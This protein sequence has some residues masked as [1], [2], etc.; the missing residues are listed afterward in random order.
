M[1]DGDGRDVLK[2]M[3]VKIRILFLE[4]WLVVEG[5]QEQIFSVHVFGGMGYV[6]RQAYY[7]GDDVWVFGVF[8]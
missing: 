1:A 8:D 3:S 5:G 7:D 2:M 6:S 4:V